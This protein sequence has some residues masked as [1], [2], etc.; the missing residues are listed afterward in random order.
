MKKKLY[1]V[2]GYGEWAWTLTVEAE[3]REEVE[4][5]IIEDTALSDVNIKGGQGMVA[6]IIEEI[7]DGK[8]S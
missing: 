7:D 2:N 3:S 5:I 4:R 1:R 6:T 8:E